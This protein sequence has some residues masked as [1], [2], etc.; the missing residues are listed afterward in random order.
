MVLAKY[1]AFET[2]NKIPK[3][4]NGS[5]SDTIGLSDDFNIDE[6]TFMKFAS[7]T[8]VDVEW[9]FSSYKTLIAENRRSFLF[10]NMN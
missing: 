5:K 3:I 1:T 6:M 4:I 7:I 9:R 10:E 8:S 2:L